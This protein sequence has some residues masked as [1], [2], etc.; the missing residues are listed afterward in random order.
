MLFLALSV[1]VAVTSGEKEKVVEKLSTCIEQFGECI[2]GNTYQP[3]C[4]SLGQAC[5]ANPF[6]GNPQYP[7]VANLNYIC[8]QTTTC[9][10]L[11]QACDPI[12]SN[13][14]GQCCTALGQKCV[15]MGLWGNYGTCQQQCVP[16]G[17]VC[18]PGSQLPSQ[19]C[20]TEQNQ[21]CTQDPLNPLINKCVDLPTCMALNAVC[22]PQ[23]TTP[24]LQCCASQGHQCRP[25]AVMPGQNT[26][27]L[28]SNEGV[29]CKGPNAL[30][31]PG[32]PLTQCCAG[33]GLE[34][35]VNPL[36][37]TTF[38]CQTSNQGPGQCALDKQPCKV[39][40]GP[41]CCDN[42]GLTCVGGFCAYNG[43]NDCLAAGT[44]C[45]V[46]GKSCCYGVCSSNGFGQMRCPNSSL[47]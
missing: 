29:V 28:V 8:Q 27:Q 13:P 6:K 16:R 47:G 24:E 7:L 21:H 9:L 35:Q 20:C 43:G 30:C 36:L 19:Q 15:Q 5:L 34:C 40:G 11:N 10:P 17:Q 42:F 31:I 23:A 46:F 32:N 18:V 14:A 22:N 12:T 25:N 2:P 37:P 38:S 1:L 26:C 41:T 45:T 4:E 44:T 33:Q 3:C 39:Q